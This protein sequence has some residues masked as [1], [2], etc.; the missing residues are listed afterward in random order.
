MDT[1][2]ALFVFNR[3]GPTARVFAAIR[4]ARPSRLFV[5]GD[6]PRREFPEDNTLCR[7]TREV[8]SAVD[9]PCEVEYRYS[10][11]NLGCG[12]R[13]SSGLDPIFD[14]VPEAIILEDDCMPDP[15]FFPFAA[16]MLARYRDDP[17][18][19]MIAGTNYFSDPARRESYFFSRYFAVWGW[20]GWRRAWEHY[21]Y[22]MASWPSISE[23]GGFAGL[24]CNPGVLEYLHDAF[25]R[26]HA[27]E[28]DAWDLRW[29][30][31]CLMQASLCV[32]P[33]VN[34]VS[35][36]GISGTHGAGGGPPTCPFFPWTR[37]RW[38]AR[39]RWPPILHMNHFSTSTTCAALTLKRDGG[40]CS[41]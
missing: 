25:D 12:R 35:N 37:R 2:V 13:V 9:W 5:V 36:V 41:I 14:T 29:V 20:A 32:V 17:R 4:A 39:T 23:R 3:P 28:V 40:D 8:V 1:Q 19:G 34:L 7:Q 6:G 21:D 10:D 26:V 31:A 33:R 18:V 27:G 15:S 16:A 22:E 11:E 24:I 38:C 30:H